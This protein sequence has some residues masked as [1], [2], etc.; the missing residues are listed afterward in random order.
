MLSN[1]FFPCVSS[2]NPYQNHLRKQ[3]KDRLSLRSLQVLTSELQNHANL[4]SLVLFLYGWSPP[5][6]EG[7]KLGV[8]YLSFFDL[9]KWVVQ[10][11]VC[12][13]LADPDLRK[14]GEY[15]QE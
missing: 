8:F 4:H 11:C 7:A 9:L 10:I 5:Q 3:T 1:F 15:A 6:C 13:E 2:A 12:V 14:A